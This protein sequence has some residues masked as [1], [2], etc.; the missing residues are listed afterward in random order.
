[1]TCHNPVR[2]TPVKPDGRP[3]FSEVACESFC[4]M[5]GMGPVGGHAGFQRFE[6]EEM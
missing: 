6:C 2:H 5:T 3:L 1:M 4:R